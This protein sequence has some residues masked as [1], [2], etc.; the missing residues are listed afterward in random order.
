VPRERL[1][2]AK[3][4]T[5][6][7]NL[8]DAEECLK[9]LPEGL[10]KVRKEIE[11]AVRRVNFWNFLRK[12]RYLET[13]RADFHLTGLLNPPAWSLFCKHRKNKRGKEGLYLG[14][15]PKKVRKDITGPCD[16]ESCPIYRKRK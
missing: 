8:T 1:P 7:I 16:E 4:I 15:L 12:C 9:L 14:D 11:E 5:I 2:K 10:E 13:V 6:K 3:E